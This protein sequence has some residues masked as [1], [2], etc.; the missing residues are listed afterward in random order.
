MKKPVLEPGLPGDDQK[1]R[2]G[3]NAGKRGIGHFELFVEFFRLLD[4]QAGK[5]F[6][7]SHSY[8]SK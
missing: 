1:M 8:F 3:S 5:A 7:L 4:R 2:E 6:L